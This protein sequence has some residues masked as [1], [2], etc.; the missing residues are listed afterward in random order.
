M[1]FKNSHKTQG[2]MFTVI[3]HNILSTPMTIISL[4]GMILIRTLQRLGF[5]LRSS[6]FLSSAIHSI[7]KA[8]TR[9]SASEA[10][11]VG[12]RCFSSSG[13]LLPSFRT[14]S[15]QEIVRSDK[16]PAASGILYRGLCHWPFHFLAEHLK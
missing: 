11:S 1:L 14:L 15:I 3:D 13:I 4:E 6:H 16:K 9:P 12:W 7:S 2:K 8:F 10:V 5:V